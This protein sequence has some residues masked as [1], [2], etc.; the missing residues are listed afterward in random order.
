MIKKTYIPS[1]PR[2]P[3]LGT[4]TGTS[5]VGKTEFN[6]V[7]G[8]SHEHYNKGVLDQITEAML[9]GALRELITSTDTDAELTDENILSSLRVLG[10]IAKNNETFLDELKE[11]FLSKVEDDT[12]QGF[13]EFLKG[14]SVEELATFT[15][16]LEIG[17]YT[18]GFLG[19]GG[20]FKMNNGISELEVD[21]LT[22]RMIATFFEIVVSKLRHINGGIVLSRGSMTCSGVVEGTDSWQCFFERGENNEISNTF[23]VNDQARCQ[24]FNGGNQK[25]YWRLVTEVGEDW[26][27]L[28]KTVGIGDSIPAAGDDIVQLGYQGT[29][30]NH[31]KRLNA[32]IID[33]SGISQYVE[34]DNFTLVGKRRNF[35]SADG[36]GSEFT[37]KVTFL[38][39]GEEYD[40]S[41]WTYNTEQAIQDAETTITEAIEKIAPPVWVVQAVNIIPNAPTAIFRRGNDEELHQL[42]LVAKFTRD[43]VDVTDIMNQSGLRLYEFERSNMWGEDDNGN[44]DSAWNLANK[45]RTQVTLTHE[46]IV[47]IGNI[48]MVFND[49]LLET[50]Y[51]KLK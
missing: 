4:A 43:G 14:I 47:F 1:K 28:S 46:D 44:L 21:K 41:D 48:N 22:V 13:I 23:V 18:S 38:K 8:S 2:N 10:E 17:E 16:G 24:V 27:K 34:I 49:E 42:T 29:D 36:S 40:L 35:I 5:G 51:Q 3:K 7:A 45:G 25:F 9:V 50:E 6:Q 32:Q 26:I 15:Q 20:A 12:A 19:G 30:L 37:G 39:A 33:E 11:Q 31:V